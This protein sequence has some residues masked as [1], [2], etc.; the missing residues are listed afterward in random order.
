MLGVELDAGVYKGVCLQSRR[1][2]V[3]FQ[4]EIAQPPETSEN[5]ETPT[6]RP[7]F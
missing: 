6:S 2:T 4:L 7:I 3:T 5:S 1:I